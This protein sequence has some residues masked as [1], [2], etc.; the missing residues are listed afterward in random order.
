MT[1]PTGMAPN[2]Y[3]VNQ[4][5]KIEFVKTTDDDHD[6]LYATDDDGEINKDKS[7]TVKKGILNNIKTGISAINP[8]DTYSFMKVFGDKR[9]T[10]LF[11]FL[12][13]N[14]SVEWSQVKYGTNANYLST[15]NDAGAEE[16]GPS[17]IKKSIEELYT[18][19]EL[20]H[21][22]PFK[23][24]KTNYGPSNNINKF[25]KITGDLQNAKW[26][27]TSCNIWSNA[28]NLSLSV[29]EATNR[30]YIKYNSQGV[31]K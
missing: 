30:T 3:K 29:Y 9:A 15:M 8:E 7:I 2:D 23:N 28:R 6:V 21:S 25:G 10:G 14:T 20:I 22:H 1:D 17:L 18:V 27:E 16:G 13:T 11:E 24:N 31:I 4:D 5:G 26:I 12:A 19:R